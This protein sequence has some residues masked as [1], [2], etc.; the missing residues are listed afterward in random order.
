MELL[1]SLLIFLLSFTLNITSFATDTGDDQFIYSGLSG[2]NLILNGTAMVTPDGVLEFTNGT[3]GFNGY[4]FHPTPLKF[5]KLPN[6]TAQSFSTTFVFGM[7][8]ID[9]NG[10]VN[11]M[12]FLIFA[13]GDLLDALHSPSSYSSPL[14]QKTIL[15]VELDICQKDSRFP[16]FFDNDISISIRGTPG[17]EKFYP[18]GFYDDKDGLFNNLPL[19]SSNEMQMWVDYDANAT[20]IN[21]TLAPLKITKPLRPL[22]SVSYNLST[23]LESPAYIGFSAY[24]A[25]ISPTSSKYSVLGW[26]FGLNR[27]SPT[28]DIAKLP[29]L[30]L[31]GKKLEYKLLKIILPVA[32]AALILLAVAGTKVIQLARRRMMYAELSEDWED[33]FGP[34]RFSYKDLINATEGF[35]NKNLLGEGGFGKVYKGVLP[36]SKLQVAVKRVSHKSKQ[37]IKE[38]IAEVISIGRLRHRNLVQL[39]GYCRRKG[40]LLLVYEYMPNGSLDRYLHHGEDKATLDW[41]QRYRLIKSIA[42]G[43]FYLHE[44]WEKVVI[45]RDI[46]ASNVLLDIEMNGHLSVFGLARLC[47]HGADLAITHVAGT[48]GY[49]AP[50]LA[51]TGKA[52]PLTDVYAFGIFI[53]EVTCGQRPISNYSADSPKIL[54]DWVLEH[55][56]NGTLTN[57]LDARIQGDYDTDEVCLVLKLG[58]LCAHPFCS[59]RPSMRQVMQY[60]E[61]DMPLPEVTPTNISYSVLANAERRFRPVHIIA[62]L[63]WRQWHV[64]Q[65]PEWK[66][67]H[68]NRCNS[69]GQTNILWIAQPSMPDLCKQPVL[70]SYILS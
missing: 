52:S 29:K 70:L 63:S 36:D 18:A 40:E 57:P 42:S 43:L 37:G 69:K 26:S 1:P 56:H 30:P 59:R 21:V 66:M 28:I 23:L 44:K 10:C 5:R 15:E 3:L 27:P 9:L 2:S 49:I 19:A 12:D 68:I 51:R 25:T 39:L 34:H 54:V 48:L 17:L 50:E 16:G 20:Q 14:D 41:N 67:I 22:L 64:I 33:E 11:S 61:G 35:N 4:A 13:G 31:I 60:L 45:H 47:D 46:K 6:G 24:T 32:T 8:S 58:L 7:P 62:L 65:P 38:F 55:C 53:L